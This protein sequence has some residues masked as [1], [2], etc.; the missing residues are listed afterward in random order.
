MLAIK[1][2][3]E[4]KK[5]NGPIDFLSKFPQINPLKS[6]DL[7]EGAVLKQKGSSLYIDLKPF[8]TGIIYGREFNNARDVI[9]SLKSGDTITAKIVEL[10]NEA[11]YIELSLK[12]AGQEIIWREAEEVQKKQEVFS[13]AVIDANKGGLIFDWRGLPGFL[14]ASQLKTKHYPRV[15]GGD[16]E[17]I[18]DELKKLIGQKLSVVIIDVA[19]KEDKLIFSEKETESGELKNI[20]SKYKIGDVIEGEITGIVDFGVF[21]KIEEGLEGLAHISELDWGLVENPSDFFEVGQKI[22]AQIIAIKDD[23]ISLSIKALKFNPWEN[24]KNKY[25]KDSLVGGVVI[26]YNK[27][28]T[29][30]SIEEGV[31]GLVH[32]SGFESEEKMRS[33]LELGKSYGFKITLFEPEEQRLILAYCPQ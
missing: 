27:Y 11:G 5:Q 16:K 29:L 4:V 30:V 12:E 9:K 3:N 28:G 25:K 8:G 20:I 21:I 17:K 13:L 1:E 33:K 18:L 7:V 31:A 23:K 15:E 32:I 14:P 22:S 26:K 19:Q 24:A 6:G 2:K 10:E